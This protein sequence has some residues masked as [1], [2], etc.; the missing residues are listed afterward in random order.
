L[1]RC[2]TDSGLSNKDLDYVKRFIQL[3]Q[4]LL[5][6]YWQS[7]IDTADLITDLKKLVVNN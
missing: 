3:N 7:E 5:L 6:Q 2:V 4:E 1:L